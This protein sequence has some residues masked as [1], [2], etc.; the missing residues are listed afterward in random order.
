M[1]ENEGEGSMSQYP[2]D[3]PARAPITIPMKSNLAG[4]EHR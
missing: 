2:F 1:E 3:W 4:V